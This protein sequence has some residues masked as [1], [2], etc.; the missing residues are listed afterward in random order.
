MKKLFQK[1]KKG[2]RKPGFKKTKEPKQKVGKRGLTFSRKK[3]AKT[4]SILFFSV[5]GFSLVFN[6][7]FFSK[8]QV[9]RNS[10]KA[11]ENRINNQLQQVKNSD[12]LNSHAAVVYT[13]DFLKI[14]FA[15]P[16][17]KEEREKRLS[18]LE[19][20]FVPG[21]DIGNIENIKDFN[22][23][24]KLK[25]L[26]F[27]ENE[28]ISKTQ[29]K[30]HFLASYEITQITVREEKVKEKVEDKKDKKGKK[31]T[32]VVEKV[33]KK[34]EPQTFQNSAEIVVPVTSD[35]EGFA[36]YQNPNI[37][38][39]DLKSNVKYTEEKLAGEELTSIDSQR[40]KNFLEEFF[41][42]YGVS[43]EKLPFM[44]KVKS[45]LKDQVF[46]SVT[47]RQSVRN[48]ENDTFKA[49][50]DVEYQNK[51][52]AITS[53]YTYDLELEKENNKFFI[54]SIQ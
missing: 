28:R 31:T 25:S 35:G 12:M 51:Q 23:E 11:A 29:A 5:I 24:R 41:T 4:A 38:Q 14:Y 43:D 44:A 48:T 40:L 46:K 42:S 7:I 30:I 32:K 20:Y 2:E 54:T 16:R 6:V 45:G 1:K 36:V 13:E 33:V 47:I 49:I 26:T 37:I 53:V 52:T 22:G 21:F 19:S 8:Y 39:R 15:I 27:I 17:S 3:A 10:A 18:N 50:V 9:I 34:E